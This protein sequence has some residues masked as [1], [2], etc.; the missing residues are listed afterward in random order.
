MDS[1]RGVYENAVVG[2]ERQKLAENASPELQ[3]YFE[4]RIDLINK[5]LHDSLVN[6]S[7][8]EF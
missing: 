4:R 1:L 8:S 2:L 7:K 6:F 5:K 3:E